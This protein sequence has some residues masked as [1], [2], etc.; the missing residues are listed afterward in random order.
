MKPIAGALVPQDP[1]LP[2][3]ASA[4]DADQM[5]EVFSGFLQGR[6][7]A[8]QGCRVDRVKYR[9]G[10][11]LSVAYRLD[12]RDGQ[13]AYTQYIAAR[14]CRAG[15]SATRHAQAQARPVTASRAGPAI[16][17]HAGLEMAAHWWPNDAKLAAGTVLAD[18]QALQQHWLPAVAQALGAGPCLGHGVELAQCVPEHRVTARVHLHTAARAGQAVEG[19]QTHT[20]YAKSDAEVRGPA[21]HA[22]MQSLWHSA[23]RRDGRLRV[24][25]PL[26][27]QAGSGL[28]WQAAV[29]GRALLD[30]CPL[31]D[32]ARAAAVGRLLAAL[33]Q[34]PAPAAPFITLP[35]LRQRV[36]ETTQLLCTVQPAWATRCAKVAA[37]LEGGLAH[38]GSGPQRSCTLHGDLHPRNLL[39]EGEQL[40]LIDLDSARQGPALLELGSWLADA[41]YRAQLDGHLQAAVAAGGQAFLHAYVQEGGQAFAPRA[42]AWA[43][44]WQLWCQR[45]WRCVVNLK[46]GRFAL[47]PA[48]LAQTEVLLAPGTAMVAPAQESAA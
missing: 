18:A 3:L 15:E 9:A 12:L 10:R 34:T 26:L 16:S 19:P 1:A 48:L 21:T 32:G 2:Q 17:H 4:L 43:T 23:A 13:G 14:F 29:P 42:V 33:H 28:H 38:I 31:P 27:W 45:L 36:L 40:S 8:L 30:V 11:N 6:D 24:P 46:P 44:A 47:L 39:L 37:Q 7:A 41:L 5:A 22:V 25:R 20:V 35:G